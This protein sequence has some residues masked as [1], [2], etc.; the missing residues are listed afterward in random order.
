[1]G[2]DYTDRT[3]RAVVGTTSVPQIFIDGDEIGGSD[4]LEEWLAK[5]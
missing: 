1:M 4:K 2:R 3:L 5:S